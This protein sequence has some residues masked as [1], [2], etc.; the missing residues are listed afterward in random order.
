MNNPRQSCS[1]LITLAS[2]VLAMLLL[3]A[4]NQS[5]SPTNALAAAESKAM[6]TAAASREVHVVFEGPW[7]FAPD[8]KDANSIL[9]LAPK[10]ASHHDLVIQSPD[11]KLSPGVYD[12]SLPARTAPAAGEVDPNILRAK[13][14]PQDVQHALDS[15][16]VRYAI[17]L[18][19]PEAYVEATHY[20]SRAAAK[21][22]PD[23]S[24]E[25]DYVTR[26]SLRYTVSSLNGFSLAGSPD[27]GT[28]NPLLLSVKTPVIEFI[29]EPAHEPDP[30]DKC[31][32]HEREAFR[33]LT[34]LV[35]VTL[36]VD[37]PSDPDT[38]HAK[39]PQSTRAVK[40]EITPSF[41][42]FFARGA[43][44]G[45]RQHLLAAI[46]FFGG[47]TSDCLTPIIVANGPTP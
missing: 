35:N 31:H 10:T 5:P 14:D 23:T 45:L 1:S 46:Y 33:D 37:F 47:H 38:C 26:V 36:F 41:P 24:T 39:D 9:A 22:P 18:P 32:T 27:S 21:Y 3:A 15:K 40:A 12:L 4:C 20:R 8:P 11:K 30:A 16:L 19:K 42:S 28:F 29:I 7:A 43:T 25:K 6:A 17:R 44:G 2:A 34:K 13:I